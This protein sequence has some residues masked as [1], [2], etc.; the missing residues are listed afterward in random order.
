MIKKAT[1]PNCGAEGTVGRYC[2][3]CGTKIPAPIVKHTTNNK[4]EKYL[5]VEDK[6]TDEALIDILAISFVDLEDVPADFFDNIKVTDITKYIIPMYAYKGTYQA[7]WSCVKLVEET[8]KVG[9]ETKHITKRY[10]MNG[11]ASDYFAYLFPSCDLEITPSRLKSF[12][13]YTMYNNGDMIDYA[14]SRPLTELE[15]SCMQKDNGNTGNMVWREFDGSTLV[16]GKV[17]SAIRDQLPDDYED[18]SYSYTTDIEKGT[19]VLIPIWLLNYTYKENTYALITDGISQDKVFRHPVD[20]EYKD[21][22]KELTETYDSTASSATLLVIVDAFIGIFSFGLLCSAKKSIPIDHHEDFAFKLFIANI[23]FLAFAYCLFKT[24]EMLHKSKLANFEV[25]IAQ[26]AHKMNILNNFQDNIIKQNRLGLS[27]EQLKVVT[28]LHIDILKKEKTKY[29]SI[30][31]PKDTNTGLWFWPFIIIVFIVYV[32][33]NIVTISESVHKANV[34]KAKRE[35]AIRDSIKQEKTQTDVVME[36]YT[37]NIEPYIS[38]QISSSTDNVSAETPTCKSEEPSHENSNIASTDI[39]NKESIEEGFR[40]N[41]DVIDF[42]VGNSYSHDGITL[43]I[44]DKA[45]Y[46]NDNKISTSKPVFRKISSNKGMITA[47]PSISI[48]VVRD[49]NRLIDNS[50]GDTYH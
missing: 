25:E 44:T 23:L 4:Q 36:P 20:Q 49:D 38:S 1:C 31:Q 40:N 11:I 50:N 18:F 46:A 30:Q 39:D 6:L 48:T 16:E 10:P 42:V 12:V 27:A 2:E 9:E 8:Y 41:T 14:I 22:I 15:Q 26:I 34:E 47:R 37:D 43:R 32:I 28:N 3:Y 33:A 45:V 19:K 29:H 21:N 7:P 17:K 35:L 24:K 5:I 13:M